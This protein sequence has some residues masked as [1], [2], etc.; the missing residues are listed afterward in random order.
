MSW[1][2]RISLAIGLIFVLDL[3]AGLTMV[4]NYNSGKVDSK[5]ASLSAED[6][7]VGT[8]YSGTVTAQYVHVGDH[9]DAGQPLFEVESATLQRDIAQKLV[10][11]DNLTYQVKDDDTMIVTATN[12]GQ[13]EQIQYAQGAFVP[14]NSTIATVQ[15][16]GTMYVEAD[17]LLSAKDYSKIP[18]GAIVDVVLPNNQKVSATVQQLQVRTE[19]GQARTTIRAYSDDLA[20]GTGLFA[21]GTPVQ[22]TLHLTNDGVVTDVTKTVT[23]WFGQSA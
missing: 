13:V 23:G 14:A 2:T 7:P 1:R 15:E 6:Y 8:D 19:D 11:K 3:A 10:N 21:V 16:A 20:N 12:A 17:F 18:S 22:A 9:V 5:S 4:V